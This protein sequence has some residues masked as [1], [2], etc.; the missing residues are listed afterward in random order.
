MASDH[1]FEHLPL[2]LRQRGPA[3]LG[4]PPFQSPQTRANR[5]ARRAHSE[6]LA[7]A[8]QALTDHYREQHAARRQGV[9]GQAQPVLPAGVPILLQVDPSL[10]LDVLRERF[11]FEIVAEQEEGFVIVASEDIN[12]ELF[13]A[14]VNEFSVAV[15]GSA[16]VASV[17]HLF[18]DPAERLRRILSDRLLE[19]WNQANDDQEF[20]VDVGVSC[21]G[22]REIPKPPVK[23]KRDSD[24]T[25]AEKMLVWSQARSD[26]Y[27]AW[28]ELREGRETEISRII[29]GYQAQILRL[30]DEAAYDGVAVPDSFTIRIRISMRGLRDF[31]LNYP[32]IFEVLEP[33]DISLPQR[34]GLARDDRARPTEPVPPEAEA[35][36]VCVVDSGIQ[37]NHVLLQAAIDGP[38]SRCFL[39][40]HPPGE[41]Q[42]FVRPGGHG[43]RV[44]GAVL[45]GESIP[46]NGNPQLPYWIQNARVLDQNNSMPV[47]MPPGDVMRAVV[48]E[49]HT[50]NRRT[51]IFNHSINSRSFCR[52]R[53]MS[54]WAA[55]ID[56]LSASFDVLVVQSAGNLGT[57]GPGNLIGIREHLT[58]GRD[59][60]QFLYEPSTRVANPAQ[61]LQALTVGS[62]AYGP[63]NAGGWR[64]FAPDPSHPSAFTRTG[65]AIWSVIKP[66]V[67]EYGGDCVRTQNLPVDVQGGG[68][69]PG[70]C[71]ELVRSTMFAPGPAFDRDESG[72]SY[73]TPKVARLAAELQRLLPAEPTLL[74][75]ALIVQSAR[76]PGWAEQVLDNLRTN[77]NLTQ[78]QRDLLLARAS[79]I[80]QCLG[81]GVP[82]EARATRNTD[83]RTTLVT[84]GESLIRARDC[85]IYQVPVPAQLRSP[86]D[87]FDIRI[88]VT[89]SYAAQP[90]RTRRNLRRYLSTWLD[91]KSSKLGE[92]INDFRLRAMK[93]EGDLE[94]GGEGSVL[95]WALQ[96]SID[97]GLIRNTK[98]S[99]GTVQKDW[100]VVKSNS[101]PENFCIAVMGHQG[102]SHDPDSTARYA[103]VVTIEILGQEIPIYERLR[104]AVIELQNQLEVENQAEVE[105]DDVE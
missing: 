23:G 68:Q 27:N 65:P 81:Y 34:D 102:W 57:S 66:E 35:P 91:W 51:R 61:S 52:L 31:V 44:A 39:V 105:V 93:E 94:P 55:E 90:R 42:D 62:I 70:A 76:W 50:Q 97:T 83:H 43:T 10:D 2:L 101:L 78:N 11:D 21:T 16:T 71:P 28:D 9:E 49:Y 56:S 19:I 64:T 12:L 8:S 54:A 104:T 79:E 103:L 80:I 75:R 36:A 1:N 85:H 86:A 77:N 95:P 14:M 67:V 59:Y 82:D 18:D 20:I 3:R 58:A 41:V 74:Y 29:D 53:Y 15:H 40:G 5:D 69:V 46:R 63:L 37:E 25:W 96:Q 45:Y 13:V 72:T 92:N 4:R 38:T 30:V 48:M 32:Y 33:E 99:N 26:V 84:S 22:T 89:L 87:E 7:R 73:A 24:A 98:R 47:E 60:P 6:S 100:A 17:Y 88:E